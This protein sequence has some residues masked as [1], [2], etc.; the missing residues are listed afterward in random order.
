MSR[1]TRETDKMGGVSVAINLAEEKWFNRVLD[2]S[3]YIGMADL[4]EFVRKRFQAGVNE[5]T[6]EAEYYAYV[7]AYVADYYG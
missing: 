7:D 6:P 3:D 2:Y 4:S 1:E 5:D